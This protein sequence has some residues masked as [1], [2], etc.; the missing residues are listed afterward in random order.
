M[1]QY[2][3]FEGKIL[4]LKTNEV[5]VF[6]SN[7]SGFH[8]AGA[9]G[10]ALRGFYENS[11]R[12]DSW[13]LQAMKSNIHQDKI[14]KYAIYGV[15]KGF[16]TGKEGSSYAIQTIVRPGLKRSIS[17]PEIEQQVKEFLLFAQANPKLTFYVTAIGC[18]LAG[19]YAH[20][21]APM[22]KQALYIKNVVLTSEFEPHLK[23]FEKYEC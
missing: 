15:S 5:I 9:A 23:F 1:Q 14:G 2:R 20:E 12:E 16:M 21:I 11:W 10:F 18:N 19:Y 8:G 22:F 17:L 13:F 6:G 7:L 4:A 3:F